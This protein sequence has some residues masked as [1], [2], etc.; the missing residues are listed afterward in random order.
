[1]YPFSAMNNYYLYSTLLTER[2][3][4]M[5]YGISL[6]IDYHRKN[7]NNSSILLNLWRTE[8]KKVLSCVFANCAFGEMLKTDFIIQ[9]S[10]RQFD[11]LSKVFKKSFTCISLPSLP[12]MTF[13]YKTP[14]CMQCKEVSFLFNL[15]RNPLK[16]F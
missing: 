5:A 13:T 3:D 11:L 2:F 4:S 1:M 9:Y 8:K 10:H 16:E 7:Y 6:W 14:H 15:K 12:N